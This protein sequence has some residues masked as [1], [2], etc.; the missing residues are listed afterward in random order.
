MVRRIR[1][2]A[3]AGLLVWM[4]AGPGGPAAAQVPP[5]AGHGRRGGGR[6]RRGPRRAAGLGRTH[7]RN[8]PDGP[9]RGHVA[10]G[11]PDAGRSDAR[12]CDAVRWRGAGTR[13]RCDAPVRERGD[14]VGVRDAPRGSGR[15]HRARHHG[16]RGGGAPRAADRRP[17]GRRP[18]AGA[19]GAAAAHRLLRAR[20][21]GGVRRRPLPLRERGRR[22]AGA[23]HRRVPEPV[24]DRHGPRHPRRP[25]EGE[26]G[27][28]MAAGSRRTTCFAPARS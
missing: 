3:S 24:G 6:L 15:Q 10:R 28:S 7:R 19:D 18:D 26:H 9:A 12:V 17:P 23:F 11:R 27:P 1:H 14:G 4:T 20:L 21:R 16:R 8:D 25:Q 13:G 2:G 22:R 5:G